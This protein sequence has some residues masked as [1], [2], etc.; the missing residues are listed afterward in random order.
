VP[1]ALVDI[2][3]E[4]GFPQLLDIEHGDVGHGG[5]QGRRQKA[6]GRRMK[7]EGMP[8]KLAP[9]AFIALVC[10]RSRSAIPSG[11]PKHS[12]FKQREAPRFPPDVNMAHDIGGMFNSARRPSKLG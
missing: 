8:G 1:E 9:V 5:P 6:E 12:L 3:A 4:L 10:A 7:D 2:G 11:A